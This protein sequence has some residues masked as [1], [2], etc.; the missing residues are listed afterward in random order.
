MKP[1]STT[2]TLI[3]L[4]TLTAV[5]VGCGGSEPE[6][7]DPAGSTGAEV[8]IKTFMYDP[9]PLTVQ[10]GTTVTFT[11]EDKILHTVTAGTREKPTGEFDEELDG[12]GATAEIAVDEP[13]TYPYFCSVHNGQDGELIVE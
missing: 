3:V 6:Q 1:F 5:G 13:G 2:L 4:A 11:N 8:M 10:A 12:A 9:S 7:S